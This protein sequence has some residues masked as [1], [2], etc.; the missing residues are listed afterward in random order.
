M[1]IL[2][3]RTYKVKIIEGE[4][5]VK[6]E[7]ELEGDSKEEIVSETLDLFNRLRPFCQQETFKKSGVR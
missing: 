6:Q 2:M 1:V 5:S 4:K 7:I 3:I